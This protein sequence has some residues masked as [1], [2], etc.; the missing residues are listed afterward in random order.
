MTGGWHFW[1]D[2]GGTF[3]DVVARSPDGRVTTRK[4]LSVNPGRYA[5]AAVHAIRQALGLGQSEALPD[6][7]VESI[8][9]GTT[10]ATNALLEREG[11]RTVLV[12]TRGFG[13]ALRIGYQNRPRLFDRHIR[14][15]DLLYERVVEV[16]ER[17]GA[18]GRVIVPLDTHAAEDALRAAAADGIRACAICLVHGYRFPD[19]EKTLAA[20]ARDAG[21]SQ[22]SVSHEVS[23]L[24]KLVSRG[25]T[26]VVDA[27]LS[28]VL[29]RYV[30]EVSAALEAGR[31]GLRLMF[32]QSSGGL[33]DARRFAGKDAILSGPAGGVV[34]MVEAGTA[35][36]FDRLIGFDMG[37]TSTDVSHYAGELERSFDSLVAGVRLRAPMIQ[38]H[39][40]AAGGGSIL[41][42]DGVRMRVGPGFGRRRSRSGLLPA[43]RAADRHRRQRDGRQ[44]PPGAL[45]RAVRASW[46]RAAR[47]GARRGPVPRA[48]RTA[49]D[50]TRTSWPTGSCRSPWTTWPAPSRRSRSSVATTCSAIRWSASAARGDSMP[51]RS[52]TR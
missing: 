35:A 22:V 25:D 15:P 20:L 45:S 40:V 34:G 50:S 8:R 47:P 23:P 27:Y 18:D 4:L 28:P 48:G 36:G 52:P 13:D 32:M 29:R 12:T 10:V 16:D 9:I 44:G 41:A 17:I 21:F 26:T 51:A 19:H 24:M 2:R 43:R 38:V 33:A 39:T 37:G 49:R 3:T 14:L 46:R 42:Y 1:I 5:D 7:A 31:R 6:G 30:E 11:E